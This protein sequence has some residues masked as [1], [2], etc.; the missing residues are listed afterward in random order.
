MTLS[1]V[2][3]LVSVRD[4]DEARAALA[5]G[6]ALIDVKEP[7]RGPMG[8]PDDATVQE[9]ARVVAGRA[10][11]SV[12]LGDVEDVLPPPIAAPRVPA[13]AA[14]AKLGLGGA[15]PDW[16]ARLHHGFGGLG[17]AR[18]IVAAYADHDLAGAPSL[19]EALQAALA[20]R[21]AGLL[22]DTATKDGRGLFDFVDEARLIEPMR[23]ARCAGLL[24]ALAGSL[25]ERTV[26]RAL[27][28]GPDIIAVRGA[29]CDAGQREA[30]V[31][32][33]NVRALAGLIAA[34]NAPAAAPAG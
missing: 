4:A 1:P 18:P 22:I 31:K 34:H 5:G 30:R 14:Y 15:P 11:V 9:V 32:E 28:L 29:A 19:D 16:P 6:A 24:T 26:P 21:A 7:S 8:R 13:G 10:P 27:A 25:N 2:R 17:S 33:S 23:A 12:A 20:V 3:L